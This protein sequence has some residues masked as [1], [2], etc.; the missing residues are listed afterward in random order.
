MSDGQINTKTSQ[1]EARKSSDTDHHHQQQKKPRRCPERPST[2][3]A[4]QEPDCGLLKEDKKWCHGGIIE[5]KAAVIHSQSRI[6]LKF[7]LSVL[8]VHE[9]VEA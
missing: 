4:L 1:L 3:K 2:S 9:C 7:M 5:I 8:S 6:G